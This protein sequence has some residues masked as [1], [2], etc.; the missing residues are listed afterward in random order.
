VD[1]TCLE[2]DLDALER[3]DG[4]L[5]DAPRDPAGD[6]LPHGERQRPA[7]SASLR[8]LHCGPAWAVRPPPAASSDGG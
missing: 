8:G 5:G 7:A 3:R 1:G 4:G 2:E 6:E